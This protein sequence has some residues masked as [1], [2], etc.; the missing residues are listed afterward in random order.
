MIISS[1]ELAEYFGKDK[2]PQEIKDQILQLL[3]EWKA[4]QA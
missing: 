3:G 2:P 1:Q 4:K